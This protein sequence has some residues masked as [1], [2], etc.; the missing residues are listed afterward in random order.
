[1][2]HAPDRTTPHRR[3]APPVFEGEIEVHPGQSV[4][5]GRTGWRTEAPRPTEAQQETLR[6]G[7]R[8][9]GSTGLAPY[10]PTA[11]APWDRR[12]ALHLI[13]R[14]SFGVR[15][16]E[17]DALLAMPP[18]DAVNTLL[19][20]ASS[21][22]PQSPPA[23]NGNA[24]PHWSQPDTVRQR[25]V[26]DTLEWVNDY[27]WEVYR[28]L[29]G[30][31][32]ADPIARLAKGVREKLTL[33]WHGHFVTSWETYFLAPWLHRYWSTLRRH[34]FGDFRAFVHDIGLDPSMLV[35]LNGIENRWWAPNENYAR[36]LL[37]LFTM[38]ILGD[39]GQPL[40]TEADIQELSRVLTGWGVDYYGSMETVFVPDW[41]DA[42]E[43]TVFGRTGSWRYD[44]VVPLIFDAR[45]P[46]IARFI[47]RKLYRAFVYAEP[48]ETVVGE[49][50]T[51]FQAS[52][53]QIAPV[54]SALFTSAHFFSDEVIGAQ[55]RSPVEHTFGFHRTMERPLDRERQGFLWWTTYLAGQVL[56]DPP[57]VA[58]WPGHRDWVDTSTISMRWLVTEWLVNGDQPLFDITLSLSSPY[59]A[60]AVVSDLAELL[61][62][63]APDD[64]A[65]GQGLDILLNGIPSYEWDPTAPGAIWRLD[66]L[67][68]FL[69]RL[70]E[71]QLT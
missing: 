15:R 3:S 64:R 31:E 50:A 4:R 33:F 39:D 55:I 43:K 13:R 28:Q 14:L 41:H 57:T 30:D 27:E 56:F 19:T 37:E 40:Y 53:W 16:D 1:M 32:A 34:A 65:L 9:A 7:T 49:M 60:E 21:L 5:L 48:D 54:L 67:V 63:Q 51:L 42:G 17:V 6:P 35:Y 45:A 47:C 24:P 23:W 68:A 62:G 61:L 59:D 29:L 52:D 26:D 12:R 25:Y 36:E 20:A 18:A 2:V 10:V 44:D 69:G 38:G 11:D 22:P 58:G 46:E 8:K 71:H 66:A 70:P